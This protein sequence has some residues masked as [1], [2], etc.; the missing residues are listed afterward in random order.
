MKKLEYG[1]PTAHGRTPGARFESTVETGAGGWQRGVEVLGPRAATSP[2]LKI[3]GY[4]REC[5]VPFIDGVHGD[6][7]DPGLR[8]EL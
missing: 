6:C 8:P 4:P 7:P 3:G 1:K 5:G 2:C